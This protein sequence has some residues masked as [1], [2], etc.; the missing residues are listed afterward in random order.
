M[1]QKQPSGSTQRNAAAKPVK[2]KSNSMAWIRS[3]KLAIGMVASSALSRGRNR[4]DCCCGRAC[5]SSPAS[6]RRRLPTT[7]PTRP[8][9]CCHRPILRR[10][11]PT[12]ASVLSIHSASIRAHTPTPTTQRHPRQASSHR[13]RARRN[14]PKY[15]RW[16]YLRRRVTQRSGSDCSP[17]DGACPW[18]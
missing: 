2:S 11:F 1:K 4:W 9:L 15:L 13:K 14:Q 17:P 7:P 8:S 18:Q 12:P 16:K 5:A 6:P 3:R 10:V